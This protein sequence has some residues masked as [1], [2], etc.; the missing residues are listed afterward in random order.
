[1]RL[2]V[3]V[4][5]CAFGIAASGVSIRL[6]RHAN[7]NWHTVATGKTDSDGNLCEWHGEKL[8]AGTYRIEA[9]LDRYY[10]DL[11]IVPFNPRLIVD[12]RVTDTTSDLLIPIVIT[13]NSHIVYRSTQSR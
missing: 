7:G 2:S 1:M 12:F 3:Q 4:A 11:G 6:S 10:T 13:G 8:P 5:D 9:D